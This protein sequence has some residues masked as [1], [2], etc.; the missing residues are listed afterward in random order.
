MVNIQ[1]VIVNTSTTVNTPSSPASNVDPL[2]LQASSTNTVEGSNTNDP[3]LDPNA[4]LLLLAQV[5]SLTP[6]AQT[7]TSADVNDVVSD[8][9]DKTDKTDENLDAELTADLTQ[10]VVNPDGSIISQPDNV[11]LTWINSPS[12][13]SLQNSG[14]AKTLKTDIPQEDAPQVVSLINQ[15]ITTSSAKTPLPPTEQNNDQVTNFTSQLP[16]DDKK[17]IN[18]A[19]LESRSASLTD[20]NNPIPMLKNNVSNPTLISTN[21]GQSST[22][23][24]KLADTVPAGTAGQAA[25]PPHVD[26]NNLIAQQ[27]MG[28]TQNSKTNLEVP[29]SINNPQWVD[30]FSEQVFW[31]GSQDIKSAVIKIHPEEL[32]PLQISIKMDKDNATVSIISHS[33]QV[34]D[35]VD[36]AIPKLKDMMSTNGINLSD[37]Q[38]NTDEKARQFSQENNQK[39][40]QHE[41]LDANS[42]EEEPVQLVSSAKKA[43]DR[44]IDYFA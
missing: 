41:F 39:S 44:L 2:D 13:Q 8:S 28:S 9:L 10:S 5:L 22:M 12:F 33:S 31:L 7:Q 26:L 3:S 19:A 25:L 36:Q 30:K 24:D 38:I 1:N 16:V 27:H 34:S 35:L 15:Q 20:K 29:V 6:P 14:D 4:F 21:V 40:E 32:G 42:P 18:Q 23:D 37:V 11:A 17:D 43:S